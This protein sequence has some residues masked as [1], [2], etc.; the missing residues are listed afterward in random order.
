[1][2][3][4]VRKDLNNKN[5]NLLVSIFEERINIEEENLKECVS[6]VD[7]KSYHY[8]LG[9]RNSYNNMKNLVESMI[10][11]NIEKVDYQFNHG[12][13]LINLFRLKNTSN[14]L[15]KEFDFFI[16]SIESEKSKEY[17]EFA[18]F[19]IIVN[20]SRHP[21]NEEQIEFYKNWFG[22]VEE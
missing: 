6:D 7:S 9:C 19:C 20:I 1:M 2:K 15:L 3:R 18:L 11:L 5:L 16:K 14:L 13:K 21:L 22:W 4:F 17:K 12:H 8:S 10:D